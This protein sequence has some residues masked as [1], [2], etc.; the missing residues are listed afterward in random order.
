MGD[1]IFHKGA[2]TIKPQEANFSAFAKQL[3]V[4]FKKIRDKYMY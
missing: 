1:K 2:E 3:N 4:Y